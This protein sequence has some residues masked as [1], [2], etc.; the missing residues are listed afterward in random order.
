[1]TSNK[2]PNHSLNKLRSLINKFNSEK[3]FDLKC[4]PIADDRDIPL[5]LAE[6]IIGHIQNLDLFAKEG[7]LPDDWKK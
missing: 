7:N 4:S 6:Q 5:D 2:S 3:I 1:M